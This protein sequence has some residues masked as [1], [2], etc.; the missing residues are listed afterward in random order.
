V[1]RVF[2]VARRGDVKKLRDDEQN[3]G[4]R[5]SED[6]KEIGGDGEEMWDSRM[7]MKY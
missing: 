6:D 4:V 5:R 1:S 7:M 2:K 3:G